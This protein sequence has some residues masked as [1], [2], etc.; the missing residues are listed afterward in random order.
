MCNFGFPL[1]NFGDSSGNAQGTC[2]L[3]PERAFSIAKDTLL[4]DVLPTPKTPRPAKHL[5]LPLSLPPVES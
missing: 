3:V 2:A 1:M 4:S 5:G